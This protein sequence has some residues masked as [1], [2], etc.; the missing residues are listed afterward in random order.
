MA[1]LQQHR[2]VARICALMLLLLP[3]MAAAQSN[4]FIIPF[5][6]TGDPLTET[7]C[8]QDPMDPDGACIPTPVD[9]GAY[10]NPCT[11]ENIDVTG[12]STIST[13]QTVDNKG[14]LKVNVS[15]RTKGIGSGWTGANY[16]SA[17]FSGSIY[18]V[19]DNQQFN[20][21][22]PAVGQE[23]SSDFA[24]KLSMRGAKS[25]DNWTIRAHFRIKVNALGEVQVFLIN[26]NADVCKG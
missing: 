9:L 1:T 7:Q 13:V 26:T 12:S 6:R 17:I 2:N 15:V 22:L 11:L 16:T 4:T 19:N 24:D 21:R 25:I 23:F 3:G 5:E 14:A 18:A 10:L 20:F 8:L